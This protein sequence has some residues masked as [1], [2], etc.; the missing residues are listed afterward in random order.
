VADLPAQDEPV[1]PEPGTEPVAEPVS[2][3]PA[4]NAPVSG[5]PAAE[6]RPVPTATGIRDWALKSDRTADGIRQAAAKLLHEHPAVAAERVTNEHGD[7]EQLSVLLERRV[8]ELTPAAQQPTAHDERR[9]KRM[10]ALFTE[11]GYGDREKYHQVIQRVVKRPI[12]S[13]KE[14]TSDEVED[15]IAAME[16]RKRQLARQQE[17][18]VAA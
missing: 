6:S 16:L 8:R 18:A 1:R 9:R 11:L 7:D 5:P 3:P 12:S 14:L 2:A 4:G 15:L 13:S 17:P 10:F